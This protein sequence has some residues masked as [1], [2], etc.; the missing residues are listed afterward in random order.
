M[1]AV[2][3]VFLPLKLGD[4]LDVDGVTF[5]LVAESTGLL[6]ICIPLNRFGV[7]GERKLVHTCVT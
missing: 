5:A 4:I 1:C 7:L 6:L 3:W 2:G